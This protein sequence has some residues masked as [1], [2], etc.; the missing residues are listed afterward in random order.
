MMAWQGREQNSIR[1]Y[2]LNK[3]TPSKQ[4]AVELQLLS[5]DSFADELEIVEDELIDEYLKGELSRR[6]RASFQKYFLAHET[7][8][9]KLQA[10]EALNRHL[11]KISPK[12]TPTKFEFFT[13]FFLSPSFA[14]AASSIGVAVVGVVVWYSLFTQSNLQKGLLALN[15][16]YRQERPVEARVA[17]LTYAP[18][19]VTR[20]EP[21][22]VNTLE[23]SRAESLLGEAFSENPNADTHHALGQLY[24]LQR[25][26]DKAIEHLEQA[27]RADPNNPSIY[28]DLGAA[29]LEKGKLGAPEFFRFSLEN[30]QR[31]LE[32]NPNLHEALFNRALVHQYQDLNDQAEADWRA[33]LERDSSSQWATEA[34]HNLRLLEERKR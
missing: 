27:K 10:S 20:G 17:D 33:Y 18:Y 23:R 16:A 15:D 30:L 1:K 5:D 25:Q 19:S 26:P 14:V 8:R 13:S 34:R 29:Y 31:A 11:E 9:R 24:L 4:Q 12:P 7:R 22:K 3:L 32:L 2:L 21:T 28:A 6:E